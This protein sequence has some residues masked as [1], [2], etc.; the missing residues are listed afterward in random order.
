MQIPAQRRGSKSGG[1]L[2]P[3]LK[4]F[5]FPALLIFLESCN[6]TEPSTK[7]DI[8]LLYGKDWK[9]TSETVSPG[10][11]EYDGNVIRNPVAEGRIA[12]CLLDNTNRYDSNGTW[13]QNGG[14]A[15]CF[16]SEQVIVARGI[17]SAN[18]AKALLSITATYADSGMSH[19]T[20]YYAGTTGASQ[21]LGI[22]ELSADTLKL[23][24][25]RMDID[26]SGKKYPDTVSSVYVAQ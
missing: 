8:G 3:F 17:W 11:T 18:S 24:S 10:F 5:L 23:F 14:A 25:A 4:C 22:A 7:F 12:S 20:L 21:T 16:D 19:D 13:T 1:G 2:S 26:T 6:T 15:K 9:L